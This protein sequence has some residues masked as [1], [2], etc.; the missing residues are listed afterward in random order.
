[1]AFCSLRFALYPRLN[2]VGVFCVPR[3]TATGRYGFESTRNGLNLTLQ[4]ATKA[5]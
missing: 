4:Q 5:Q 1:M 2:Y 3:L